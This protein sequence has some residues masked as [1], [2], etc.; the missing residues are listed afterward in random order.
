[1][2]SGHVDTVPAGAQPW[3]RDPFGGEVEGNRLYGRGS[4]DMKGGVATNLFV[5]RALADL[6]IRL[7]GDVVFESVVD[8]E[9]GGVNGTIAGRLAGFNADAAVISEPSFLRV[10]PAQRAGRIAHITL[11]EGAA[12]VLGGFTGGA[13]NPLTRLLEKLPEFSAKRRASAPNHPLYASLA[14]RVPVSVMKVTTGPWGSSEPMTIPSECRVELYWQGMPGEKLEQ[15]D[16]EFIEWL[17]AAGIERSA[18]EFPIRW[19]PGSAI[20]A[21]EPLVQELRSCA[22]TVLGT[23]PPIEGIEAPC[24]MF[25]FHHFGIP[26]V[27]WGGRGGNTHNPDEYVEIDSLLSAAETL[28]LFVCRW[29]GVEN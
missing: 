25:A 11:T 24:D 5:V 20:S 18:V 12:G 1:V 10:C 7:A 19:L 23:D 29:C 15:I 28:L 16:R 2:L 3:S 21:S 4:N 27:H 13:I 22:Q 14:D 8:E 26:A 9:F 17:D 6:D